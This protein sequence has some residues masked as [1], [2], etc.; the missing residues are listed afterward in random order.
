MKINP[1]KASSQ[2]LPKQENLTVE[3]DVKPAKTV[4]K[5]AEY[6]PS[7]AEDKKVTY[8]KPSAN[9]VDRSLINELKSQSDAR[10]ESLKQLVRQMLERQGMT[11]RDVLENKEVE[12]DEVTRAEAQAMIDEGGP[13]SPEAVSD[14]LV[15]F[16]QALSGGDKSKF[17]LL[18]DAIDQ[19]FAAAKTALGG[20]LPEISLKTYD[21]VME[22]LAAWRDQE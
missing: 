19:G 2:Y 15:E 22:K 16:A 18:V 11:F 17:D 12:V 14:H 10:F 6:I 21:L 13:F 8:E 9:K 7:S 5:G 20:Q 4:E 3:Q 1:N